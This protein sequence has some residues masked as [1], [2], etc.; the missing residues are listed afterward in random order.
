MVLIDASSGVLWKEDWALAVGGGR[1][2]GTIISKS[3]NG[4]G[5]S[6]FVGGGSGEGIRAA[7]RARR[8]GDSS[9]GTTADSSVDQQQHSADL[10]RVETC[11]W[12]LQTDHFI[13]RQF[14]WT[15]GFFR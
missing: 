4:S 11:S 14:W 9:L 7:E 13:D 8:K 5:S 15:A 3:S 1:V 10:L 12:Q 6:I 2:R